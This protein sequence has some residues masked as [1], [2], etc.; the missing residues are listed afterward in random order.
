MKLAIGFISGGI[1]AIDCSWV[2]GGFNY[3]FDAEKLMVRMGGRGR[4]SMW[5]G[6]Y[7]RGGTLL[8]LGEKFAVGRVNPVANWKSE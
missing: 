8:I 6:T 1:R 7:S 3:L 4:F 5:V 2:A